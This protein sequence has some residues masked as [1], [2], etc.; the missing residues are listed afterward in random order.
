MGNMLRREEGQAIIQVTLSLLVLIAFV[1]LAVDAGNTVLA[2]AAD[3]ECGRCRV[4][5]Q[6]R[7]SCAW[8][9]AWPRRRAAA[10]TY[11]INNGVAAGAIGAGDIVI[12]SNIVDVIA[13]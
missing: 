12:N 6:A 2:A 11:M 3:A 7:V 10:R 13:A 5:W 4:R 9:A 8:A 1:A